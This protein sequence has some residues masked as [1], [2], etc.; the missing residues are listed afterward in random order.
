MNKILV[1]FLVLFVCL[2]ALAQESEE[3]KPLVEFSGEEWVEWDWS[4]KIMFVNGF[5]LAH[6]AIAT[7]ITENMVEMEDAT[8][9][10]KF[11]EWL[12]LDMNVTNIAHGVDYFYMKSGRLDYTIWNV[13]YIMYE[14]DWWNSSNT[15]EIQPEKGPSGTV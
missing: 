12:F 5:A 11:L 7:A 4:H 8:N 15:P 1:V 2:S 14:K 10:E 9:K 6:A 13:I 3:A